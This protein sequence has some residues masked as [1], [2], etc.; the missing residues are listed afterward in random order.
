VK[1]F[2]LAFERMLVSYDKSLA[3]TLLRP[4][5]AVA[6]LAEFHSFVFSLSV[7]RR[8]LLPEDGRGQFVINLKA[9]SGTRVG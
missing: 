9:P 1:R 7:A 8:F 2:D 4:V 5:S 6:G 3:K